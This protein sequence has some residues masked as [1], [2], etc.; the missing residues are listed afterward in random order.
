MHLHVSHSL[1]LTTIPGY[2]LPRPQVTRDAPALPHDPEF[3]LVFHPANGLIFL[4]FPAY[5]L[6]GPQFQFGLHHETALTACTIVAYNHPGYLSKLRDRDADPVDV[7]LDSVLLPGSYYY[8]L[9]DATAEELYPICRDFRNW[10]FPHGKMPPSWLAEPQTDVLDWPS[11]STAISQKVKDR[12]NACL[13]SGS[14]ECLT[15]AHIVSKE[16]GIWVR[17]MCSSNTYA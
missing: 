4:R 1:P 16:D 10:K 5:D 7:A 9:Y 17:G 13:I 15:T 3:I 14:T 8:H 2:L 11:G 12:D 6:P